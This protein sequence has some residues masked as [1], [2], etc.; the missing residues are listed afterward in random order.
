MAKTEKTAAELYREERK[1]RLAKAA[2]KNA[3][4]TISSQASKTAGRVITIILVVALVVSMGAVAFN[5]AGVIPKNRV[6]FKVGDAS[7]SE[8]EYGY[9]YQ[10]VYNMYMQ[11][12]YNGYDIGLDI[13]TSPAE[14]EYTGYLGEIEDFPEDQTPMWTDFIEYVAKERLQY[15]KAAVAEAETLGISLDENELAEVKSTIDE[16]DESAASASSE[17]SRYSLSAYLK[18]NYGKGMSKKLFEKI[19]TEQ[20]IAS[21]LESTKT[22]EY[23]ASFTDKEVKAEYEEN[24]LS[25]GVTSLRAYSITAE[26]VTSGEGDDATEAVTDETMA[27]AKTKAE[28]FAAKATSEDA[29]KTLASEAE[30][31]AGAE[32]YESYLTDDT[33]TLSE[34]ISYDDMSYSISDEDFL[35][36]AFGTDTK[37]DS[38]FVLEDADTGY[39]VYFMTNPIHKAASYDT[40]DSRHILINFTEDEEETTDT[41]ETT[42]ETS[43]EADAETTEAATTEAETTKAAKEEVEVTTLDVSKYSDVTIDLAVNAETAKDKAAYKTAQEI[44]EKY[45]DGDRTAAAFGELAHEY[46]AD[47]G[48]NENGGLYEGTAKGEF[49]TPYEEWCLADGRKEGD[50]GIVEY[51]GENYSGYH[52]IY[53]VGKDTVTWDDTVREAL[54]S[55]KVNEYVEELLDSDSAKITEEN[56]KA[57]SAVEEFL[58]KAVKNYAKSA[59]S[60]SSYS[61]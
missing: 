40:Y 37:K 59:S 41:E 4:K 28:T 26:K 43:E 33:L 9:Y 42:D 27:A 6:A 55:E 56:E 19:I 47:T 32:D 7:V 45:L 3:K 52:I 14:Q 12:A 53:F 15:V 17:S 48:S 39:T 22:D 30:K 44:L 24:V 50:V 1:A 31:E 20:Q 34:D 21:K 5:Q 10:S 58:I 11:Y 36:W 51:D 23:K 54:A 25:Y 8:A 61:Y 18:A 38:T 16:Y 2:K 13:T 49:V 57:H 46:S 29:F 60:D 35:D